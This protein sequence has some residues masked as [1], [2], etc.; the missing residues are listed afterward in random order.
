[1]SAPASPPVIGFLTDFGPDAAPP[2]C[3]GVILS[4]APDARIVDISHNVRKYAIREGAY[5]LWSTL[6]WLPVGVHLA[7]VDPGVGTERRPI[8]IRTGRGDVLVGP[9]NGLLLRPADALGGTV[10]ARLLEN[11]DLMLRETSSTFHGR[12]VFAPV[13]AHLAAGPPFTSVGPVVDVADL[14]Q[15]RFPEPRVTDDGLEVVVLYVDSFGNIRLSIEP[16]AFAARLGDPT[17]RDF[18]VDFGE[19]EGRPRVPAL[20]ARVERAPWR[21]TFGEVPAGRPLLYADSSGLVAFG[22]SQGDAARRLGVA[23]GDRV[24]IRPV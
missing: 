24:V 10:E 6:P 21:R 23:A 20:G 12:D 5:L 8:A 18:E 3:K 4:I 14:V 22:H 16:S 17:G 15:L 13:A 19:P 2:I 1:V 7:V 9:D 11:R